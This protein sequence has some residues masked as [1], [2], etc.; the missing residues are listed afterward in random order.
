MNKYMQCINVI[1]K[2]LFYHNLVK[3]MQTQV[4]FNYRYFNK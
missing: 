3:M 4:L 2:E 1:H